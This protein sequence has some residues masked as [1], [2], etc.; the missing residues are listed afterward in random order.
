MRWLVFVA[1]TVLTLS[2]V[3]LVADYYQ[4][5]DEPLQE[6]HPSVFQIR[7]GEDVVT[8]A[9]HLFRQGVVA[10]PVGFTAQLFLSGQYRSLKYGSY[11]LADTMTYRELSSLLVQGKATSCK[12]TLIEGWTFRQFLD[13]VQNTHQLTHGLAGKGD[14]EIMTLVGAAQ[15]APEGR[16]YPDTYY[17]A[18]GMS[19]LD[20]LKRAW[21]RMNMMLDREWQQRDIDIPLFSPYKA[22]IMASLIEKETAAAYEREQIAGVFTRRLLLGMRLQTDPTVIYGMGAAYQGN[23]RK[24]DLIQDTPYNT[25]VHDGLPPTPIAMPG[26]ESLH[27]AVHPAAGISLYFVSRGNGTHLFSDTLEAHQQAVEQYQLNQHD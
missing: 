6:Q 24:Q 27:A 13:A 8:V 26:R 11:T 2:I 21:R 4:K 12:V 3:I 9:A 14:D 25:Y 10:N 7:Q 19:D 1:L 23:I 18:P 20:V 22:L 5:L 16:F 17:C 15:E